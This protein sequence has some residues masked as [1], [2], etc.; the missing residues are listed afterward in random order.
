MVPRFPLFLDT[1][2]L[3]SIWQQRWRTGNVSEYLLAYRKGRL[4]NLLLNGR[5]A[6]EDSIEEPW[7]WYMVHQYMKDSADGLFYIDL[8]KPQIIW[9]WGEGL[10]LMCLCFYLQ[11]MKIKESWKRWAT[12]S[13]KSRLSINCHHFL[14]TDTLCCCSNVIVLIFNILFTCDIF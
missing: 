12:K 8:H 10:T 1:L 13:G 4:R 11:Y 3:L 2:M 5:R 9:G 6:W 14:A 7:E